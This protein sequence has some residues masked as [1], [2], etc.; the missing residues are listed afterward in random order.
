MRCGEVGIT[1]GCLS[2]CRTEFLCR[3]PPTVARHLPS[4]DTRTPARGVYDFDVFG[5]AVDTIP[6]HLDAIAG[7]CP[8]IGGCLFQPDAPHLM[9]PTVVKLDD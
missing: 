6:A 9:L 7:S 3:H 2:I 5:D 8:A 1:C 4:F